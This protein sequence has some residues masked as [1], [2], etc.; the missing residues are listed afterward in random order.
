MN[1]CARLVQDFALTSADLSDMVQNKTQSASFIFNVLTYH[2]G[3][4]IVN[5]LLSLYGPSL[6][7]VFTGPGVVN[8]TMHP[9]N[10]YCELLTRASGFCFLYAAF[11]FD[12]SHPR[13]RKFL[14]DVVCKEQIN[15]LV[16][17]K[18]EALEIV[19]RYLQ[20]LPDK[21][22]D[23]VS[24]LQILTPIVTAIHSGDV[25]G[26]IPWIRDR[27]S[28]TLLTRVLE[29]GNLLPHGSDHLKDGTEV[30]PIHIEVYATALGV[31]FE[32]ANAVL[33][34]PDYPP[35][36]LLVVTDQGRHVREYK[37]EE[38][39]TSDAASF[40]DEDNHVTLA[41]DLN[42]GHFCRLIPQTK[43]PELREEAAAHNVEVM[44]IYIP[45][46]EAGQQRSSHLPEDDDEEAFMYGL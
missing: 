6:L 24:V 16:P 27:D 29:P 28:L 42:R 3:Q 38:H 35:A 18:V 17:I 31:D 23:L 43:L 9:E 26:M 11:G 22:H 14:E 20:E 30:L 13:M 45:A 8:N 12:K 36:T 25:T 39:S 15:Q 10:E 1:T 37:K 41:F 2:H 7:V 5:R 33:G 40:A 21:S 34:S 19:I 44:E 32:N 4:E 46:P